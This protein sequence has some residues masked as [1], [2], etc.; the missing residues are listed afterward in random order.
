[1]YPHRYNTLSISVYLDAWPLIFRARILSTSNTSSRIYKIIR[2]IYEPFCSTRIISR[3]YSMLGEDLTSIGTNF[4]IFWSV[5]AAILA[6]MSV[7]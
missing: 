2:F 4:G 5:L 1:M 6:R 3:L 7:G